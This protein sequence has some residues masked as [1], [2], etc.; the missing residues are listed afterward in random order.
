MRQVPIRLLTVK[1]KNVKNYE[2]NNLNKNLL[3]LVMI[4][5]YSNVIVFI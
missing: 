2:N 5:N 4:T 1:T 3:F